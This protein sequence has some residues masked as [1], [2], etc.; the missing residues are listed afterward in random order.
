MLVLG[1]W[2]ALATS[3]PEEK[4]A[5]E[6]AE[7]IIKKQIIKG[8]PYIGAIIE[9]EELR[10]LINKNLTIDANDALAQQATSDLK[11]DP[12]KVIFY[13][14]EHF[15]H[16]DLIRIFDKLAKDGGIA[17]MLSRKIGGSIWVWHPDP[18]YKPSSDNWDILVSRF[19]N[20]QKGETETMLYPAFWTRLQDFEAFKGYM[21]LHAKPYL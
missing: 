4:I 14:S 21:N 10:R 2:P 1:V 6:I 20:K 19:Y 17:Y 9:A 7:K 8:I 5:Q 13:K 3:S 12:E 11:L 16:I 18:R 15:T